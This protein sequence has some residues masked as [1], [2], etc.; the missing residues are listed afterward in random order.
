MVKYISLSSLA[1]LPLDLS[2]WSS[3][4]IGQSFFSWWTTLYDPQV[5]SGNCFLASMSC[6]FSRSLF[7]N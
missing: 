6:C 3:R 5:R 2:L 7:V 1:L 4:F